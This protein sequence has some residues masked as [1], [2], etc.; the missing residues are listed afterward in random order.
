MEAEEKIRINNLLKTE[1]I[2]LRNTNDVSEDI[3]DFPHFF[4]D[5][6]TRDVEE[7][8]LSE[9]LYVAGMAAHRS[10]KYTTCQHCASF[11]VQSKG[12]NLDD[13]YFNYL[14]RGGLIEPNPQLITILHH[15]LR[16]F[17]KIIDFPEFKEIFFN[18][19][20]QKKTLIELSKISLCND[21]VGITYEDICENGHSL[22]EIFEKC[23]SIFANVILNNYCKNVNNE[24]Q[25]K[26]G[27]KLRK[28]VQSS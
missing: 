27:R 15:F 23:F 14:Q 28:L 10:M 6:Y 21:E 26:C 16:V 5:I 17:A 3:I 1:E 22:S 25:E 4:D 19:K 11:F 7:T 13:N 18:A 8:I 20:N 24:V 12:K 9:N 2:R